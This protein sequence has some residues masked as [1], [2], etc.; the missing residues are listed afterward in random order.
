LREAQDE[1]Q[2]A[3]PEQALIPVVVVLELMAEIA[4]LCEFA[5]ALQ[6]ETVESAVPA[7]A[8]VA[9]AAALAAPAV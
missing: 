3:L 8:W 4:A 2:G 9:L 1:L 5:V 7:V 6:A